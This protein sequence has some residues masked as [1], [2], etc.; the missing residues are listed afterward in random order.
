MSSKNIIFLVF[1]FFSC[2][3]KAQINVLV[4]Y[5]LALKKPAEINAGILRY[6]TENPAL[7]KKMPEIWNM[8]GLDLGLRY[9]VGFVALEGHYVTKFKNVGSRQQIADDVL[10]NYLKL[11]DQGISFGVTTYYNRLGFGAAWEQHNFRMAR[12]FPDDKKYVN[13]FAEA[14][15]YTT[16]NLFVD[17]ST[18]LNENMGFVFRPYYQFGLNGDDIN[19]SAVDANLLLNPK[20]DATA[21]TKWGFWGVKFIFSNGKQPDTN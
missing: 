5:D 4:G 10:K 11:N 19:Q 8:N 3:A 1:I 17:F 2:L 6:N 7:S 12:K 14:K 20:V 13:A 21:N 9:R 15:K 18:K 16:L